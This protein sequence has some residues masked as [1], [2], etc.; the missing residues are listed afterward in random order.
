MKA[1]RAL[2]IIFGALY[3]GEAAVNLLHISLPGSI[4]GLII[5]TTLLQLKIIKAQWIEEV[6]NFLIKYMSFFFIP[7][8]VALGAY[9]GLIRAEWCPIL[10][11]TIISTILVIIATA[12]TYKL[13]AR[14]QNN[15]NQ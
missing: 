6:A 5:L 9:F 14:R 3:L 2:A 12:F 13:F 11:S 1:I 8:G 15:T 7:P 10:I 4:L